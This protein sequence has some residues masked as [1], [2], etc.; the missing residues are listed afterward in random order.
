MANCATDICNMAL[1]RVG[2]K[3]INDYNDSTDT[4][5]EAVYCRLFYEPT[6][7]ALMRS[8]F[9]T[10]ARGRVQLSQDTVD[11]D[12]EY[13]YQYHLPNDCLRK[14]IVYDG[15]TAPDGRCFSSYTIEGDKLLTDEATCY[16]QYVKW[17]SDVGSWDAL[18]VQVMVLELAKRL[19]IPLSLDLKLKED[20]DK[21]LTPLMR[22][23]RAMDREES[24]NIGVDELRR[25][26]DGRYSDVA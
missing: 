16:L 5:P 23:V 8:H 9:W 14:I 11:P 7:K 26:Q 6:A 12:F 19:V 21:E 17:V 22:Y 24:E 15:S 1:L 2:A 13:E 3:R 25:W 20:I 4:K 10:F 18:F